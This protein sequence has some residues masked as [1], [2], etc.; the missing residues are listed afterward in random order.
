PARERRLRPHLVVEPLRVR[1]GRTARAVL[2]RELQHL[3][4]VEGTPAGLPLLDLRLAG[5][6]VGHDDR[7]VVE[8]AHL[9]EQALLAALH[10]DLVVAL[11]EAPRAG[12]PAAAGLER[13]HLDAHL[14][15]Q[16]DLR[17]DA[18]GR[19]VVAVPPDEGLAVEPRRLDA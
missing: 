19:L 17:V 8:L 12:E 3:R 11:L 16:L 9:R 15:Q 6:P 4:D 7:L 2:A 5:E 13:L 1:A 18:A 14:L 10:R